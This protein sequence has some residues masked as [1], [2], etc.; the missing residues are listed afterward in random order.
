MDTERRSTS[1]SEITTTDHNLK[2]RTLTVCCLPPSYGQ[3]IT[4]LSIDGGGIRGIIPGTILAYL[5]SQLQE[6]DGEEARLVDYFDVISG[7]STGGLIVGML[8]AQGEDQSGGDS[9]SRNRNRP[10]FEAKE[11]VPFYLKHSP[12]IFPQPRGILCG[13]GETL[14][15]LV[16]G[17]KFNGKYLHKLIEG[18]LGDTKLTQSLTN[19]VIPCFDIKKLQP[20]I[21]STYQAVTNRALDAKLSDICISTSAAPT[22]FP[23]HRFTNEDNEGNKHEYNLIDGGI[24]ANNPTLCAIAEVTKQIMK[25]NPAM[26]DISPLD[27]TRFLVISIG[28]G[29]IRNQEKYN[30]EM[31]SKWGLMCWIFEN[32]ST[33]ILD[34]Y[35]EA[36]HDMVDYQS[37]VVFQALR[38]EKN[39]LRIDDDTLKGDLGSVDISTEKNMEGLIEVGEALLKKRVSRVNLETGHYQPISDNVTNEEA[40]KRFAKVLSDER[41]LR[42]SRS[43][44]LNI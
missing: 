4:I 36:I 15:R 9:H 38:S 25:K 5:E 29:S 18:F 30:A 10:L 28:T 2:D 13:W 7:T 42:E 39:Y 1:S 37:S 44:K 8:A 32:G 14:V 24:A 3:L 23:A 40:L 43:P 20:V 6:L 12:K 11:I 33:P 35:N 31:A 22:Y 19:V 16:R 26:G 41:K 34:C 17:P 21:F 27:F